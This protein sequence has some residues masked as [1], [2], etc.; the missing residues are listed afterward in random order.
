M[1]DALPLGSPELDDFGTDPYGI[2]E[3]Q[4]ALREY[5]QK[6]RGLNVL[7]ASSPA[8]KN[9]MEAA[10]R[11]ANGEQIGWF[12]PASKRFC[13]SDEKETWPESRQGYTIPVFALGI[14]EDPPK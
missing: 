5:D 13:Y 2:T 4:D 14:T 3:L 10:R 6:G 8:M 1:S 7:P 11:A 9:I 12:N